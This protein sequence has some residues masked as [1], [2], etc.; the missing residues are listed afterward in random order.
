MEGLV[1]ASHFPEFDMKGQPVFFRGGIRYVV[2]R[3]GDGY[4]NLVRGINEGRGFLATPE[5]F[6]VVQRVDRIAFVVLDKTYP[7]SAGDEADTNYFMRSDRGDPLSSI[8]SYCYVCTERDNSGPGYDLL[9]RAINSVPQG[10]GIDYEGKVRFINI[11]GGLGF[12]RVIK[13]DTEFTWKKFSSLYS[14]E[15]EANQRGERENSI[16]GK[17][18]VIRKFAGLTL[19]GD[20]EFIVGEKKCIV[21]FAREPEY[22]EL[23]KAIEAGKL[24]PDKP[25]RLFLQRIVYMSGEEIA[26]ASLP[27]KALGVSIPVMEGDIERTWCFSRSRRG[28]PISQI[29]GY[30]YVL[31]GEDNNGPNFELLREA[32]NAAPKRGIKYRGF[33]EFVKV[34]GSPGFAR[35]L[36]CDP[37]FTWENFLDEYAAEIEAEKERAKEQSPKLLS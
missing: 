23:V 19:Y 18:V 24:E 35:L 22:K 2:N 1:E 28:D 13:P 31:S 25:M 26:I 21:D 30:V 27:G 10:V 15:I 29:G 9:R 5:R 11:G 4:P 17:V 12:A 16:N 8:L 6:R 20:P 33:V 32:V 14:K 36:E 3:Q 37:D 34:G 7:V